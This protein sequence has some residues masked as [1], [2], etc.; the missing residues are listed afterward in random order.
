MKV[1]S[2]SESG[3]PELMSEDGKPGECWQGRVHDAFK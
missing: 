2:K 3:G 1:N